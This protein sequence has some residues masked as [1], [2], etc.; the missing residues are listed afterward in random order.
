MSEESTTRRTRLEVSRTGLLVATRR[1][2][3][4]LVAILPPLAIL[5]S[6]A[7]PYGPED[8]LW[9][10][11]TAACIY[12]MLVTAF[13]GVLA[14]RELAERGWLI[15][16]SDQLLDE[17][18]LERANLAALNEELEYRATHDLLMGIPNRG[19]L[20][21]ELKAA[22]EA[23]SRY[24]GH[25][26]LLFLDLDHFK[27]VNDTLGHAAGDELL[28]AVGARI[29]HELAGDNAVVA[30]VGGDEL[31]V[32]MRCLNS[33][34]HLGLVAARLL[35][36]FDDPFVIDG[37]ELSV[38]S[39]IGM[40]ASGSGETADEL[41]RHADA[42]LYE[43]KEQGRGRAVFADRVLRSQRESRIRTE[44][45]LRTAL[46][47]D[48]IEAWYQ[49]EV[50]LVSGEVVAAE[51]LARWR[52]GE[53]IE[54]ASSFIGVARRAGMLEQLMVVMAEQVWAWR[55]ANQAQLPTALNVSAKHL[56]TLLML[57][58][59]DPIARP[60]LG[61]RLEIAETDIIRDFDGARVLL[62][63]VRA[64]GAQIMLDDF[65]TGFSSLRMLSDLP[66]DGIKIDRTYVARLETDKRVRG[67][68]TSLAE[69]GRS[70]DISVVAEGV[71]TPK[72]AEFLMQVGIDRAQGFL[73]SS[74]IE[75][76]AF[77]DLLRVGHTIN[78]L[79]GRF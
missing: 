69:F 64:L 25:V 29:Q 53:G 45:A 22:L 50:D 39:S 43:A 47:T 61:L 16:R 46:R 70:C 31:V 7:S 59:A 51:A 48:Q 66:I 41:Y 42:A 76:D 27:F 44:L 79:A 2:T 57:H 6:V 52:T 32:L 26:G 5:A 37:V 8:H 65:G 67:L 60:F 68:V 40:A 1:T 20:Q 34:D 49:P 54:I 36:V 75:P 15:A 24:G 4:L 72:Q 62:D 33:V 3:P 58:E 55:R 17:V 23:S 78:E 71:E 30:R 74:A 35:A 77:T 9:V 21:T 14:K 13:A 63:R 11:F 19:L 10:W 38:G 12:G 28:K 73:Y 56:P 18:H